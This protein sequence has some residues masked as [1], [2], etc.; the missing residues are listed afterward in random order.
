MTEQE[1][2][3]LQL[4][5]VDLQ[6]LVLAMRDHNAQAKT[7]GRMIPAAIVVQATQALQRSEVMSR[8]SA[9]PEKPKAYRSMK[10]G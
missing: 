4:L 6:S 5:R 10:R 1:L 3:E 8:R 2:L 9:L 7:Q